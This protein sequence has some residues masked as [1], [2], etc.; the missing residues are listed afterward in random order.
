MIDNLPEAVQ[1]ILEND[2]GVS[3]LVSTRIYVNEVPQKKATDVP[4][5]R[6]TATDS[7][8][9][10]VKGSRSGTVDEEILDIDIAAALNSNVKDIENAVKTA[11]Y[12]YEGTIEE[13]QI[14]EAWSENKQQM[15]DEDL[16]HNMSRTEWHVRVIHP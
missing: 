12:D 3:A 1:H 9:S 4:W 2:S 13:I 10:Q 5:I 16:K 6:I 15:R 14:Q 8:P 7:I 11:F